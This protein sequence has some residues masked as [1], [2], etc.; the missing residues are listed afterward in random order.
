M[1]TILRWQGTDWSLILYFSV[2]LIDHFLV[3]QTN[4]L[5]NMTL[6]P[7]VAQSSAYFAFYVCKH[8]SVTPFRPMSN[9]S[10]V[11]ALPSDPKLPNSPYTSKPSSRHCRE[12]I[13]RNSLAVGWW[14]CIP[15]L[16]WTSRWLLQLTE[17]SIMVQPATD[18]SKASSRCQGPVR[19]RK[20]GGGGC[21]SIKDL[22]RSSHCARPFAHSPIRLCIWHV[23]R[24]SHECKPNIW[25]AV[26]K[27]IGEVKA[28][29]KLALVT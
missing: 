5:F 6:A 25:C 9:R 13:F 23:Q 17:D 26:H 15:G 11:W 29:A 7:S 14:Q 22:F 1:K 8:R 24:W 3:F 19:Y 18:V 12:V 10:P 27:S 2:G 20:V 4:K 21:P 16:S 28:T